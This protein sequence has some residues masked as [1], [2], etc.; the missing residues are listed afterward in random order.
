[1]GITR[2]DGVTLDAFDIDNYPFYWTTI[3]GRRYRLNGDVASQPTLEFT[4]FTKYEDDDRSRASIVQ[5][6]V[7]SNFAVSGVTT[8]WFSPTDRARATTLPQL[9]SLAALEASATTAYFH[10]TAARVIHLK[11]WSGAINRVFVD[12]R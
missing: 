10:D 11:I 1:V 7:T 5:I 3:E 9:A 12:R 4:A 8:D 6:P 2:D